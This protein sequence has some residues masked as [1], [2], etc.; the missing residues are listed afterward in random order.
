VDGVD[1]RFGG[2]AALIEVSLEVRSGE[3]LAIIGPNGAGKT[4]LLNCVSGL[5]RP[6]R[7]SIRFVDADGRRIASPASASRARFRTSS[8]SA[9]CRCSR[10]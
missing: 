6:Q 2:V 4:S 8:S 1:L 7:G 3:V 9:T 5:Y 10:T